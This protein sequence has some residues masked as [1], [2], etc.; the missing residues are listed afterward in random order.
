VAHGGSSSGA[1]T[2]PTPTY[3][4]VHGSSGG[5]RRVVVER[6]RAAAQPAAG[7]PEAPAAAAQQ[8]GVPPHFTDGIASDWTSVCP[9]RFSPERIVAAAHCAAPHCA[10]LHVWRHELGVSAS[11]LAGAALRVRAP[12]AWEGGRGGGGVLEVLL[13]VLRVGI[14]QRGSGYAWVAPSALLATPDERTRALLAYLGWHHAGINV[15]LARRG[16][17]ERVAPDGSFL[18][19]VG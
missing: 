13:P 18:V 12:A 7:G 11:S 1:A 14:T 15:E 9:V 8:L 16:H 19:R 17:H 5:D 3:T 10:L 4:V 6:T 2:S